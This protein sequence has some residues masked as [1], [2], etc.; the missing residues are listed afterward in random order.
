M[1]RRIAVPTRAALRLQ[2][3]VL[4]TAATL[5]SCATN[6]ATG[7]NELMLV[8]Q[9]QEIEMGQQYDREVVA[10]IGLYPDEAVQQ[11]VQQLGARLAAASERPGLPWSFKVLDDPSV[12]AFA[13]PGGF[14]Y[15]TR[16]IM[17]HLENEAQLATVVGHEIGHVTA[18]HTARS[19]SRQQVAQIGLIVGAIASPTVAQYADL[20]SQGLG[21]LFLKFSRDDESQADGLGLRYMQRTNHDPRESPGVF[22]MLESLSA[23]A[24]GAGRLPEWM[25]THPAPANRREALTKAISALPQDFAGTTVD[26]N[27]YLRRLDDFVYGPDPRQGYFVGTRFLHPTMR[28]QLTFP[29]G[30][31]TQNEAQAVMAMSPEKD[32]AIQLTLAG[33]ATAE[34]AARAFLSQEGM[35]AGGT[36]RSTSGGLSFVSAPFAALAGADTLRGTVL[37][38]QHGGAV[39]QIVGYGPAARWAARQGVTE[40]ALRS[41]AVL[42]DPAALNVQPQRVDIITLDRRTTLTELLRR[43]PSPVP[44][45]ELALI[46]QVGADVSLEVGRLVKWVVGNPLPGN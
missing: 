28:F 20:A 26:R 40:Q 23:A 21:V 15:I 24:G 41:F 38:V 11:Y 39:F 31:A 43:R 30:W 46:N 1:D 6:P 27:G 42:S 3:A 7:R 35:S 18:R 14:I 34:E 8:S 22:T 33:A 36:Q 45:A 17:E 12:N 16:G 9:A 19:M 25:A 13:V 2:L 10:S 32:A 44:V 37:F 29:S 5:G 4:A